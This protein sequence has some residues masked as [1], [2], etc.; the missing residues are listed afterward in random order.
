MSVL[1]RLVC[2]AG[3][4]ALLLSACTSNPGAAPTPTDASSL[5]DTAAATTEASPTPTATSEP[6]TSAPSPVSHEGAVPA[7]PD[8]F[9]SVVANSLVAVIA[10]GHVDFVDRILSDAQSSSTCVPFPS[11]KVVEPKEVD[12]ERAYVRRVVRVARA[13]DG[14]DGV[15]TARARMHPDVEWPGVE[16]PFAVDV[17]IAVDCP[18][19]VK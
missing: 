7:D 19:Q 3:A 8:G 12:G 16:D 11:I 1:R 10:A 15:G 14:I 18:D 2:A 6:P 13:H 17:I 4:L 9:A 5:G